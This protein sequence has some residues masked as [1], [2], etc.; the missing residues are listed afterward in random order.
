MIK[1]KDV[2]KFYYTDTTATLG[3][4]N[5]NLEFKKGEFVV[6]TGESGSGKS[7]LLNVISGMDSYEDGELY[8]DGHETSAYSE[9]DWDDYRRNKISLIYQSYNLIDS[10]TALENVESV[11][12]ICEENYGKLSKKER[13]KKAMECLEK[14]GLKKQAKNKASHM[15]SGQKQRLGIARALAKNT[16][17]IIADEPTGNLDIENGMAVMQILSDLSKEKLVIVVTHNYDQAEPYATR[18]VRLYDSEVV[19]NRVIRPAADV[20]DEASVVR[21]RKH[22]INPI[23]KFFFG[24]EDAGIHRDKFA[25]AK[26]FVRMNRFA[27]PH[28]NFFI[29]SFLLITAINFTIMV[30]LFVKNMDDATMRDVQN[31]AFLNTDMT[32]IIV[33][34]SDGSEITAEDAQILASI[35]KVDSVELYGAVG[36]FSYYYKEDE[37]YEL[38]YKDSKTSVT[39]AEFLDSSKYVKSETNISES[40]LSQG[41]LPES[42]NEIVITTTDE[43]L[44]GTEINFY[45]TNKKMWGSS[46]YVEVTMTVVGIVSGSKEQ[47]YFDEDL[48]LA[49]EVRTKKDSAELYFTYRKTTVYDD[50]TEDYVFDTERSFKGVIFCNPSLDEN[51]VKMSV[52]RASNYQKTSTTTNYS[53]GTGIVTDSLLDTAVLSVTNVVTGEVFE[54]DVNFL[55]IDGSL[56][57]EDIIEVSS[58]IYWQV[59]ADFENEEIALFITDYAYTNKVINAVYDLGYEA[60]SV[61]QTAAVDYNDAKMASQF[62]MMIVTALVILVLVVLNIMVI[63]SL[64]KLKRADYIILTSLGMSYRTVRQMNYYDLI[65]F[66]LFA[67]VVAF[68]AMNIAAYYR[69]SFVTDFY[70]YYTPTVYAVV[71]AISLVTSIITAHLFSRHLLKRFKITSLKGE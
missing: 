26:K 64:M 29:F 62:R 40:D 12:L 59:Y 22:R 2:S 7:T 4:R 31:T 60:I 53:G 23:R 20:E 18:K 15:S 58:D 11:L 21:V 10:Y 68:V 16:D 69:V 24:R 33:R 13:R 27:T 9:Q 35:S 39:T 49:L 50:G 28:R 56:S 54:I 25:T 37:D 14:V 36:D 34:N 42:Y 3:L 8:F 17:I 70:N 6:I 65:T 71:V 38:V 46:N 67:D 19:E 48:C 61:Y 66:M 32:R 47:V 5:V 30:G 43:S 55:G 52:L 1:L 63:Y 51:T 57:S 41:R 44:L 45:F